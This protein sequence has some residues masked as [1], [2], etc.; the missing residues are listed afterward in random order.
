MCTRKINLAW[1][2]GLFGATRDRVVEFF[3]GSWP[4]PSRV[5]RR[6][7][8]F[9]GLEILAWPPSE[10]PRRPNGDASFYGGR[11]YKKVQPFI[12]ILQYISSALVSIKLVYWILSSEHQVRLKRY[13]RERQ[14]ACSDSVKS[15]SS[16]R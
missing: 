2:V 3:P 12:R 4:E 7:L 14:K 10:G 1:L 9:P 13:F 11:P 15:A 5:G 6:R 8:R 16:Q